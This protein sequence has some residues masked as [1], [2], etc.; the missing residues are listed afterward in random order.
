MFGK[1]VR[2]YMVWI[3]GRKKNNFLVL[4]FVVLNNVFFVFYILFGLIK[5]GWYNM[6]IG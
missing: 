3:G 4:L 5:D 2:Y 6:V 1:V